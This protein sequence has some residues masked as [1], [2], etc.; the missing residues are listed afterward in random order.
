MTLRFFGEIDVDDGVVA[1]QGVAEAAKLA[2]PAVAELG[3]A[4]AR[5]GR[6]VLQVP[7]SG[8]EALAQAL[9]DS[10]AGIG[11]PPPPRP[12]WGH[13][14][15]ARN[16]GKASLDDVVGEAVSGRWTVDEIALVAS[17]SS[18][19]SGVANSYDVVATFPL[20]G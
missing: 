9:V 7:V 15:L 3:P 18:G 13:V 16:R 10:S 1:G 20:E 11:Q 19:R 14:T 5:L 12:F 4:V 17:V 8:L 6:N 2:T